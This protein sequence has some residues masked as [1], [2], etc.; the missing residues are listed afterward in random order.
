MVKIIKEI[1]A[2]KLAGLLFEKGIIREGT[3]ECLMTA[4]S[5]VLTHT[6]YTRTH[7]RK[8]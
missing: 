6:Y 2:N 3:F 5:A 4:L 1:E 7:T 8:L